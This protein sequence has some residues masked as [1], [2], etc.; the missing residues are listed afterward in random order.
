MSVGTLAP[1][2]RVQYFDNNGAP[3]A[4]GKL[5]TYMA[6]TTTPIATYSDADLTVPNANP[7]ILDSAGRGAFFLAAT[8][9]KFV[10]KDSADVTIWTLDNINSVG[11]T[12]SGVFTTFVFA[13]DPTNPITAAAYPSGATYDKCHAGT[14]IYTL[15]SANLAAGTYKLQGMLLGS[16]GATVTVALVNLTDGAPDT[17]LV[18]I[19]SASTTGASV[20]SG[21]ITFAAAGAEKNYAIKVKVDVGIG[22]A[23][24]IQLVKVS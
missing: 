8:S 21:V 7:T 10:L 18:T 12:Q 19:S 24:A 6:G 15:N 22:F 3:L 16:G 9:Y 14:G 11:L 2:G 5:Y 20:Q 4:S 23:W 1:I 17:P 13:G